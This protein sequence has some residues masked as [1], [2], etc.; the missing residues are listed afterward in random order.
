MGVGGFGWWFGVGGVRWG[1]YERREGREAKSRIARFRPAF[2]DETFKA[3]HHL[4]I[5]P[6]GKSK[7]GSFRRVVEEVDLG[8][9][10]VSVLLDFF[11]RHRL[12]TSHC[13]RTFAFA[14][15]NFVPS[16]LPRDERAN[17]F[18]EPPLPWIWQR[19]LR[20]KYF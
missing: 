13:S 1:C 7:S 3:R 8:C 15:C 10:S 2:L 20:Q 11:S 14:R 4:A 16:L 19:I 9:A 5:A 17:L 12:F 6:R 18:F